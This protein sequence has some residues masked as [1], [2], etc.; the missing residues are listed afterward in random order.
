MI[1]RPAFLTNLD[2]KHEF[3]LGLECIVL[4]VYMMAFGDSLL[5]KTLAFSQVADLSAIL[6]RLEISLASFGWYILA[7][8]KS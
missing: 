7:F 5:S 3:T 4:L 1:C 8:R 2:C 6:F